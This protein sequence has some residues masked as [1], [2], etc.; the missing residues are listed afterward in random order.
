MQYLEARAA[1]NHVV[2][3]FANHRENV[4]YGHIYPTK[5]SKHILYLLTAR[6]FTKRGIVPVPHKMKLLQKSWVHKKNREIN[7]G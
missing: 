3:N 7:R 6:Q 2:Y 5:V 1:L 4:D